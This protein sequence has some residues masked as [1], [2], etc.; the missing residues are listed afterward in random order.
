MATPELSVPLAEQPASHTK[1]SE[2]IPQFTRFL[3]LPIELRLE[4]WNLTM[5][6]RTVV[7]HI[8]EIALPN[9][10]ERPLVELLSATSTPIALRV[11]QESRR[12]ALRTYKLCFGTEILDNREPRNVTGFF[13]SPRTYFSYEM[14]TAHFVSIGKE[15]R[16]ELP[17]GVMSQKDLDNVRHIR[18]SWCERV[19]ERLIKHIIEFKK[20]ETFALSWYWDD[21]TRDITADEPFR[22]EI[23]VNEA[24]YRLFQDRLDIS[25][26]MDAFIT[27]R[28]VFAPEYKIPLLK[29]T[30]MNNSQMCDYVY[31]L[32][33][34]RPAKWEYGRLL[35]GRRSGTF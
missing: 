9:P 18:T 17:V 4:I 27:A 2:L 34:G 16:S 10:D 12:E 7:I 11:C 3:K 26:F 28:D 14:D 6:P 15:L 19:N 13:R 5:L 31:S 32:A 33:L 20:L 24:T 30:S 23:E 8:H 29:V 1:I 25:Q 35:S 21:D 22:D